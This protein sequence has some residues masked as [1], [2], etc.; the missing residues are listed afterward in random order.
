MTISTS[1]IAFIGAV[2]ITI[3]VGLGV[4]LGIGIRD[5]SK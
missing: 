3:V 2:L 5:S 4:G 1:I